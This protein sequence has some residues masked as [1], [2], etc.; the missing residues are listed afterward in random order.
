MGACER[1]TWLDWVRPI[2]Q[3]G[4][5]CIRCISTTYKASQSRLDAVSVAETNENVGSRRRVVK[6][7]DLKTPINRSDRI[8]CRKHT[9]AEPS[10]PFEISL[11]RGFQP[12][13]RSISIH[14]IENRLYIYQ[15]HVYRS[16]QPFFLVSATEGEQRRGS[17]FVCVFDPPSTSGLVP[18][19][20]TGIA[21]LLDRSAALGA[22]AAWLVWFAGA[23]A[24]LRHSKIYHTA[25]GLGQQP[26]H[27][28][29]SV[30]IHD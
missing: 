28:P 7:L 29:R 4:Q 9:Q 26:P 24:H 17:F 19:Q 16:M 30:T 27:N 14:E 11:R 3:Y 10:T 21:S 5:A 18:T 20:R 1:R 15:V 8:D 2:V 6:T 12:V 23:R 22:R 25:W 13:N